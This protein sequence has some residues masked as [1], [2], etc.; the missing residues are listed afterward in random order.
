MSVGS[1]LRGKR[2]DVVAH[3]V[4]ETV[5]DMVADAAA[6]KDGP[7]AERL[8]NS[9]LSHKAAWGAFFAYL[10]GLFAFLGHDYDLAS[11]VCTYTGTYLVAMGAVKSD[12]DRR[13]HD[14]AKE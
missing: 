11:K 5:Q 13:V 1:W 9:F 6:G 10:G 8:V 4:E 2:D 12:G 14:A 3:Q 7:M